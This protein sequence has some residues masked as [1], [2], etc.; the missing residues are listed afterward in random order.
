MTATLSASYGFQSTRPSR[1]STIAKELGLKSAI[2][3]IHKA[4]AGLDSK[5]HSKLSGVLHISIHKALAGLDAVPYH[6]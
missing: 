6:T 5:H 4:L 3:S 1:A 2:I